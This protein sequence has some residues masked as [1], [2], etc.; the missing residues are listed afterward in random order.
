LGPSFRAPVPSH[1]FHPRPGQGARP[2]V[3]TSPG[4]AAGDRRARQ[5]RKPGVGL[6]G[7]TFNPPHK[8]HILAAREA[9][10]RLK[11]SAVIFIP[12]ASPPHKGSGGLAG[13]ADRYRMVRLAIAG[14][15]RFRA[16]PVELKRPG[17]SFTY[18]TV[19]LMRRQ[20][21]GR[22][23]FFIVG[24]DLVRDIP[25]WH[26]YR[27]LV[28]A[29]RFA[30]VARPGFPLRALRGLGDRFRLLRVRGLAVSSR[31]LR[32]ALRRKARPRGLPP[33]VAAYIRR[34]GLY[35]TT[36]PRP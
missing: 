35:G 23:L 6:L 20:F 3:S 16:S 36:E 29:V 25:T 17:P 7:G 27:D 26:R 15:R 22:E 9:M 12:S 4:L 18:D 11:L 10:R 19:R 24:A 2:A 31:S 30:V 5:P 28:R 33:A 1:A 21:P 13:A 8:G 32:A 34:R 14:H